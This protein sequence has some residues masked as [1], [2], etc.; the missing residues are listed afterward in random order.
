MLENKS[1]HTQS[2][3]CY[4]ILKSWRKKKNIKFKLNFFKNSQIPILGSYV[5]IPLSDTFIFIYH[6]NIFF[7]F[8]SKH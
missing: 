6:L 1:Q 4:L 3:D 2:L 8:F 5:G 7:S